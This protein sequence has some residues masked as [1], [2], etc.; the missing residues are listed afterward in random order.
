MSAPERK[1]SK[2]IE[3]AGAGWT[4]QF[5]ATGSRIQE[6]TELYE[7]MGLEVHLEPV[8]VEDLGCSEC[9]HGPFEVL[10]DCAVIYTRPREKKKGKRIPDTHKRDEDLW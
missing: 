4:K 5:C 6:A 3:L 9:L 8:R 7:S 2:E 1:S 10:G